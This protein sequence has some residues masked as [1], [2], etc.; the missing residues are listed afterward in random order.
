MNQAQN[1][2]K[3]TP[4]DIKRVK[5]LGALRDKRYEDIFNVRVVTRA[6]RVTA[7]ELR[8]VTEAAQRFGSGSVALTTRLGIEIQGVPYTCLA[9]L[10]AFLEERGMSAGGTGPRIRPIVSC[11]GT[12][13]SF[14]LIDTYSLAE[15]LHNRFYKGYHALTLPHKFKIAVGGCPNNCVKPDLNDIGIIGRRFPAV[16]SEKCRGCKSCAVEKACPNGMA[17][18]ENGK[19]TVDPAACLGCGRCTAQC[20]FGA[21]SV[22]ETGY[23][24][25]IGG[26]YGKKTARGKALSVLLKSENEVLSAV[27]RAVWLFRDEGMPGERFAET[28]ERIGFE[29]AEKRILGK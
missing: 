20:P 10:F 3:P 21:V 8:T 14:G 27:G 15:K 28:I 1:V 23:C 5:E 6:G 11:K 13:C 2:R 7:D 4:D 18:T 12:S 22:K 16:D 29:T 17:R 26:R 25:T 24:L 19:M 9:P